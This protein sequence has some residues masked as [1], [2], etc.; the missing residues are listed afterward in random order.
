MKSYEYIIFLFSILILCNCKSPS[1]STDPILEKV[2][3]TSLYT[4]EVNWN[5][6][7]EKYYSLI[8]GKSSV[9]AMKPALEYLLNSLGD[10]H[11]VIR[12]P[13]DYSIIANYTGPIESDNRDPQFTNEVINDISAQF[14]YQLLPNKIGYLKVVGIAPQN[15]KAN[16][17]KIRNGIIDLSQQGVSKWILDLRYNGGGDINPMLA[18]LAPLLGDGS[19]GGS[20]DINQEVQR[21]Y[22]IRANEFYDNGNL[23]DSTGAM[24]LNISRDKVAVLI[25]KYT[26]SSGEMTAI[27]FKGRENTMFIGEPSAG[28]TTGNGWDQLSEDILLNISQSVFIDRNKNIYYDKVEADIKVA[29]VPGLEL[30]ADPYV[31]KATEWLDK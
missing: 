14:S 7:E 19:I 10:K 16:A 12:S 21:E 29:F 23:V 18:G 24:P 25:S 17:R 3:E 6:V 31:I 8:K 2:K 11:A 20:V 4:K 28:Y 22:T 26:I 9:E 13:T 30:H 15:V 1:K 27:A 5:E